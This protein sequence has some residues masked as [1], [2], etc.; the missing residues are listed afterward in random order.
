LSRYPNQN[1]GKGR[2]RSSPHGAGSVEGCVH[3][4]E[5]ELR[6]SVKELTRLRSMYHTSFEIQEHATLLTILS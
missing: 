5:L 3:D 2:S 6:C 1:V 4:E